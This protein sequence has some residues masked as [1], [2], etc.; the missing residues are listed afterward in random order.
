MALKFTVMRAKVKSMEKSS[1]L[2]PPPHQKTK[3]QIREVE[4]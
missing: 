2:W 1:P 4:E 3:H